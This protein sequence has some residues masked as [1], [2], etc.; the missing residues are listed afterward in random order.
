MPAGTTTTANTKISFAEL[1][2]DHDANVRVTTDGLFL[3]AVDLAMVITGKDK[4]EAEQALRSIPDNIVH[5]LKFS[6][7]QHFT[8]SEEQK[9]EQVVGFWHA[10]QLTMVLSGKMAMSNRVQMVDNIKKNMDANKAMHA[11]LELK[12]TR[13]IHQACT[14]LFKSAITKSKKSFNN[15]EIKRVYAAYSSPHLQGSFF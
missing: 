15:V 14:L 5:S 10:I 4:D 1:V 12:R 3:Y 8:T 11:E 6:L 7:W 2:K 9:T 13:G